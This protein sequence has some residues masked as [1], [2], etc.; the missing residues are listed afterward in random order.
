VLATASIDSTLGV[1]SDGGLAIAA[2]VKAGLPFRS[3]EQ[4][5]RRTGLPMDALCRAIRLAPRTLARRRAAKKLSVPESDRLA[6]LAQVYEHAVG[7]FDGNLK[8]ATAWFL[9][10]CRGLGYVS[11]LESAETEV[12]AVEVDQLIGRLEHGVFS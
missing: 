2:L 9:T 1:K 4:F 3:L 10:P 11:P 7:F 8:S 12:G 6:R 5:Q